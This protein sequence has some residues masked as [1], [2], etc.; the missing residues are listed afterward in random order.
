MKIDAKAEAALRQ[1]DTRMVHLE[2]TPE[3]R[4]KFEGV[5]DEILHLLRTR[6]ATPVEAYVVLHF[7]MKSFEDTYGIRGGLSVDRA[8]NAD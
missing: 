8:E 1:E 6:T 5:T 3:A 4:A 2:M 7:L